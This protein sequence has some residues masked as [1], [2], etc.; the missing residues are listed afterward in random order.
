MEV[1]GVHFALKVQAGVWV[2]VCV[3]WTC[4]LD[5]PTACNGRMLVNDWERFGPISILH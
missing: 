1:Q 3:F 5:S 2:G 4:T